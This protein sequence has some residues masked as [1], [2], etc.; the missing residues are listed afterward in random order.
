[1]AW[2]VGSNVLTLITGRA[3]SGKTA[4]IMEEV[5]NRLAEGRGDPLFFLV[6]E[7]YTLQCER[8]LIGTLDLAGT[9][10]V[11]VLSLERLAL[12]VFAETGGRTRVFLDDQGRAMLVRRV[13][14]DLENELSVYRGA[15]PGFV[16]QACR[17]LEDLRRNRISPGE[18]EEIIGEVDQPFLAAKL[19]D[20]YRIAL[21]YE[22][23]LAG[24]FLDADEA[25]RRLLDQ[26]DGCPSLQGKDFF[27]DGFSQLTPQSLEVFRRIL[28]VGRSLTLALP[29]D[30]RPEDGSL[31]GRAQTI[32]RTLEGQAADWGIDVRRIHLGPK[33]KAPEIR[34]LEDNLFRFPFRH[35]T[36]PVERIVLTEAGTREAE[37]REVLDEITRLAAA[38]VRY[39]DIT[40]V[41]PCLEEYEGI[42][43]RQFAQRD[44]PVFVDLPQ[45]LRGNRYIDYVLLVLESV[46]RG[47]PAALVQAMVGTG[48]SPLTPGEAEV[49]EN[50]CLRHG[51]DRWRFMEPFRWE[52]EETSE[53]ERCRRVLMEPL[54]ALANDLEAAR[55]LREYCRCLYRF[56]ADG[57]SFGVLSQLQEEL[58][59]AREFHVGD[60][61]RQVWNILLDLLDQMVEIMGDDESD[62]EGFCQIL[63][64]GMDERPLAQIPSGIDQ[65]L[66]GSLDRT[67]THNIGVLFV[68][69][70]NDGQIP[71]SP[72]DQGLLSFREALVLQDAGLS[73]PKDSASMAREEKL[74]LYLALGKPSERLYLSY[75]MAGRQGESLR[76]SG[77][78]NRIARIFPGLALRR[79]GEHPEGDIGSGS[80]EEAALWLAEAASGLMPD[81][82]RLDTLRRMWQGGRRPHLERLMDLAFGPQGSPALRPETSRDLFGRDMTV[83][84]SRLETMAACPFAH[85]VRYGLK[86]RKRERLSIEPADIGT[87]YHD[88]LYRFAQKAREEGRDWTSYSSEE[89]RSELEER[90]EEALSPQTREALQADGSSMFTG[91]RMKEQI[92]TSL[93]AMVEHLRNGLF[94]PS[95]FEVK[96]GPGELLPP[97]VLT[98]EDGGEV[99]LQGTIDRADFYRRDGDL[100]VKLMDYKTGARDF[101]F[102]MFY[103]GLMLQLMVYLQAMEEAAAVLQAQRVI[104]AGAFYFRIG[105]PAVTLS[106][107]D[108]DKREEKIREKFQMKGILVDRVDVLAALDREA[109]E[110]SLIVPAGL[111][112]NGTLKSMQSVVSEEQLE[113][114]KRHTMDVAT[115]LS[116]EIAAGRVDVS[117]Y[118]LGRNRSACTWCD[119]K[120]ICFVQPDHPDAS[121]RVLPVYRKG[122]VLDL[123]KGGDNH[124][125]VD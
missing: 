86:P 102:A 21:G 81:G 74:S 15:R 24:R 65:V 70:F 49:F 27:A 101:D 76:P 118:R 105:D 97:L 14:R 60:R 122:E 98:L 42:M 35:W 1:M 56:L 84:I 59:D 96:F 12:R 75:A 44:V 31:F 99:V 7:Q 20:L 47:F 117:P 18:L 85:F 109:G 25:M 80:L 53:M 107:F 83:S 50:Y 113:Q 6:P 8:D 114:M 100:L 69:G 48:F 54:Q 41:C 82:N 43:A 106:R 2:K 16:S 71:R 119:Y 112:K 58:E 125:P 123:L 121:I 28:G 37:V 93:E 79:A 103:H 13:L 36:Q 19:K 45:T 90:M 78:L 26:L 68:L 52:D 5:R 66:V 34:Y 120:D 124:D 88:T 108:D 95:L 40:V 111:K 64:A 73:F 46:R 39:R 10:D 29:Y 11:Q 3:G 92:R 9:L 32:V 57:G 91:V 115:R 23:E 4:R 30:G 110:K 33:G 38:G 77:L 89:I 87:V 94:Q 17:L 116:R 72:G 61:Y 62:V 104:S 67:K 63:E 55:T 51:V 22:Q